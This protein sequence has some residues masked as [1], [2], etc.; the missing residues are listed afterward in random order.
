[1][2]IVNTFVKKNKVKMSISIKDK[3]YGDLPV[4]YCNNTKITNKIGWIP[5]YTYADAC[6]HTWKY[7]T[8]YY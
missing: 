6:E 8:T 1:M 4:S 3:R 7:Y 2:D 5:K